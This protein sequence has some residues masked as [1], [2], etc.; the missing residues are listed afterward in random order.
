MLRSVDKPEKSPPQPDIPMKFQGWKHP[1]KL[2]QEYLK[3]F[4]R[5]RAAEARAEL[6][7]D[8]ARAAATQPSRPGKHFSGSTL[9][10]FQFQNSLPGGYIP[11]SVATGDFNGDG[12]MDFV[13]ANGGE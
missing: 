1:G 13:I 7:A 5:P 2:G 10:G 12:K 8:A 3:H 11:T 6:L 9:P 4:S